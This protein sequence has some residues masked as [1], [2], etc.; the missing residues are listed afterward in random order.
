MKH[1]TK[2]LVLSLV[3]GLL[4]AGCAVPV[5]A[6]AAAPAPEGEVVVEGAGAAG[7]SICFA[8]QD[9]ETEFWVA[10]HKAIV[11][12]LAGLGVE[13]IERNANEDANK[14]LEQVKD[15]IAQGVDGIII[16]PQ[17]GESAVTIVGEANKAGIPIAVFNRPPANDS[18][19]TLVIV[20]NNE[21]IAQTA[22]EYMAEEAKKVGREGNPADHGWRPGRPECRWPPPGLPQRHRGQ[23]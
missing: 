16:I 17:D 10:G 8:Y 6:P 4:L 18:N 14:Q 13:V 1:L 12:T 21:V 20:A 5:A 19:P 23:P 3:F 15:C 9:L 7:K 2:L 11:E 22:V